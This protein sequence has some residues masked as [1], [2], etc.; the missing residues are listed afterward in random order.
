MSQKLRARSCRAAAKVSIKSNVPIK[1]LGVWDTVGALGAPGL[2]G[3]LLNQK[4]YQ[5]HNVEL[6]LDTQH[7]CQAL[8]IDERRKPFKPNVWTRSPGWAGTVEQVWFA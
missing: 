1:F 4:K 6:T 8:A 3:Q 2:L 7:A 5:Y